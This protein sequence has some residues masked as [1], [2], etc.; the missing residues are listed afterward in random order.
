[1][2]QVKLSGKLDMF[3]LRRYT[4]NVGYARVKYMNSL[5]RLLDLLV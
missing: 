2:L 1:M 4:F 5:L 3:L